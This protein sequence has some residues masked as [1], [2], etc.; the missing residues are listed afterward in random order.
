MDRADGT[1]G[2][3]EERAEGGQWM[4]YDEF[5]AARGI[6]R[7]AAVR[8]AVRHGWQKKR[9]NDRVARVHVP[10]DWVVP[11]PAAVGPVER[12]ASNADHARS[13]ERAMWREQLVRE[14]ERAD[15]AEAERDRLLGLVDSFEKRLARAEVRADQAEQSLAA[16]HARATALTENLRSISQLLESHLSR[17][18]SGRRGTSHATGEDRLQGGGS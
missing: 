12:R 6:E 14:R 18:T 13:V 8:L 4:T 11:R 17:R 15:R 3:S 1:L 9:D 5:A 10:A 16:E 7:R 2:A